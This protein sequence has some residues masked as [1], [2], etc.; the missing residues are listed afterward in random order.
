MTTIHLKNRPREYLYN[1]LT[2]VIGL[3]I[4]ALSLLFIAR[5][6]L[7]IGIVLLLVSFILLSIKKIIELDFES[8]SI[9]VYSKVTFWHYNIN[10]FRIVPNFNKV[11]LTS[12]INEQFGIDKKS[13]TFYAY[14]VILASNTNRKTKI[15][16]TVN[17]NNAE[18]IAKFLATN[19][20][21]DLEKNK[22]T[23]SI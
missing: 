14:D 7:E 5:H 1:Y 9:I 6:Y 23:N 10:K 13:S 18:K 21:I 8:K 4:L 20:Q 15:L 3:F 11:I 2:L 19:L 17:E 12:I 16:T 22:K